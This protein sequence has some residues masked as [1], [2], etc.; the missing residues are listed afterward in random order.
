MMDWKD[1]VRK[2]GAMYRERCQEIRSI[3]PAEEIKNR[4]VES[5]RDAD[6]ESPQTHANMDILMELINQVNLDHRRRITDMARGF[7]TV[8]DESQPKDMKF[9]FVSEDGERIVVLADHMR[10]AVDKAMVSKILALGCLP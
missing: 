2:V 1:A 9:D 5:L 4:A 7:A 8:L 6:L 3:I 10:L